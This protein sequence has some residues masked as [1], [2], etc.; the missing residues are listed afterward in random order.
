[1]NTT[2]T[3]LLINVYGPGARA[4]DGLATALCDRKN[5]EFKAADAGHYTDMARKRL[6]EYFDGD[7]Y[8]SNSLY[9]GQANRE[10]KLLK[11]KNEIVVSINPS[12]ELRTLLKDGATWELK[13]ST[14]DNA[15][16]LNIFVPHIDGIR[17]KATC[18][19]NAE[20]IGT[21][22]IDL[23]EDGVL[24]LNFNVKTNNL[25]KLIVN[26]FNGTN[27]NLAREA[28]E[29]EAVLD[30]VVN[31]EQTDI[32]Q[33][34]S[35]HDVQEVRPQ[36]AEETQ[37]AQQ[38]EDVPISFGKKK[39]FENN[40]FT[41]NTAKGPAEMVRI[42][43]YPGTKINGVDLTG[44]SAAFF[45]NDY[46]KKSMKDP[47]RNSVTFFMNPDR[48]VKLTKDVQ[49]PQSGEWSNQEVT[50]D[51]WELTKANKTAKK[52]FA[53][54]AEAAE[55]QAPVQETVQESPEVATSEPVVE[56]TSLAA[57]MAAAETGVESQE[58][59]EGGFTQEQAK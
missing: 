54:Q 48:P 8:H 31:V 18:F 24:D 12:D 32:A 50:V 37:A 41:I 14:V 25:I 5:G 39:I 51:P 3:P 19:K 10:S 38:R 27:H 44:Y 4:F 26:E 34:E 22:V 1:M 55:K 17:D 6:P 11:E 20:E 33:E 47:E 29:K 46:Q 15:R 45:M 52:D 23:S 57:T 56:D 40:I 28:A 2:Q 13:N 30:S 21:T 53:K 43:L 36:M 9:L 16:K 59:G 49:D 7:F 58:Y 42:Q 35:T